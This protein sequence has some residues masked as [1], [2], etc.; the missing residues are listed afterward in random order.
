MNPALSTSLSLQSTMNSTIK[1]WCSWGRTTD[2][3]IDQ[4]FPLLFPDKHGPILGW[5]LLWWLN[6]TLKRINQS[7]VCIVSMAIIFIRNTRNCTCSRRYKKK[8]KLRGEKS[9]QPTN[10]GKS[11]TCKRRYSQW[12]STCK[13][14]ETGWLLIND[15]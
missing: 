10:T 4:H 6:W 15:F 13:K 11:R 8:K 14:E 5:C 1:I 9:R 7:P 2:T 3:T 12:N